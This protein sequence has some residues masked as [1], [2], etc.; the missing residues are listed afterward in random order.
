MLIAG[1]DREDSRKGGTKALL[2]LEA[3]PPR[4]C[5]VAYEKKKKRY[6]TWVA[7]ICLLIHE[8]EWWEEAE[9]RSNW[10]GCKWIRVGPPSI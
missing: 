7:S 2:A 1:A 10:I 8:L 5:S 3:M 6:S 4:E 9:Q